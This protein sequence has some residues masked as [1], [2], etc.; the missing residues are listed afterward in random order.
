MHADL[1]SAKTELIKKCHNT[2]AFASLAA[3]LSAPME[4]LCQLWFFF[5]STHMSSGTCKMTQ[6]DLFQM[7][8]CEEVK[9]HTAMANCIQD[10]LLSKIR[11]L[12]HH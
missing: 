4:Q 2:N 9:K 8:E 3:L 10:P 1:T 5:L 6:C 7:Q 11:A 12:W